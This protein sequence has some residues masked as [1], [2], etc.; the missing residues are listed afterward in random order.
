MSPA[1][2]PGAPPGLP[3]AIV[4]GALRAVAMS[5]LAGT[6]WAVT[7]LVTLEP[8]AH[9]PRPDD[10]PATRVEQISER[11]QCSRTGFKDGTMPASAIVWTP[12]G[13]VR[14]VSFEHG[15][16]VHQG[17]RPGALLAVCRLP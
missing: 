8:Q 16:A 5:G 14:K 6:A 3:L 1:R 10:G 15:W 17:T 11:H 7:A 12:S 13:A 2:R 4:R 9:Q